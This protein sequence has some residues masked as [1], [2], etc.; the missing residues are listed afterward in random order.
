MLIAEFLDHSRCPVNISG[1]W[2]CTSVVSHLLCVHRILGSFL[3]VCACAQV[4]VYTHEHVKKNASTNSSCFQFKEICDKSRTR[5][6]TSHS[7]SPVYGDQSPQPLPP[8]TETRALRTQR[9]PEFQG[10]LDSSIPL[11]SEEKASPLPLLA[12]IVTA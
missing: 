3:S 6:R 12:C 2:E 7:P 8:S 5:S 11:F 10:L 1:A 9:E 4:C